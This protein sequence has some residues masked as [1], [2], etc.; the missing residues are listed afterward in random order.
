[1]IFG[2]ILIEGTFVWASREVFMTHG[3][4]SARASTAL[5]RDSMTSRSV[6][7]ILI[8]RGAR[9]PE[10]ISSTRWVI[11]CPT[12]NIAIVLYFSMRD[13]IAH[14]MRDF[15]AFE[16]LIHISASSSALLD[17]CAWASASARPSIPPTEVIHSIFFTSS[18]NRF[19]ISSVYS[20]ELPGFVVIPTVKLVSLNGGSHSLAVIV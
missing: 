1:M 10:T 18:A 11:G 14:F 7:Y 12:L 17:P 15:S 19:V 20:R 5:P 2:S 16:T 3:I 13:C 6:P 9:I 8:T 4:F